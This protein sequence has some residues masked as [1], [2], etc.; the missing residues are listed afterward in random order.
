VIAEMLFARA[1]AQGRG[2]ALPVGIAPVAK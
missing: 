2:V 1:R